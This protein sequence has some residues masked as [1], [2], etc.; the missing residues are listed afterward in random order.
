MLGEP[1]T[2]QLEGKLRELRFHLEKRSV[3]I[4]Y[5]IAPGRP[6]VLLTT[7][8]KSGIPRTARSNG[9][10]EPWATCAAEQHTAEEDDRDG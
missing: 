8:F 10:G 6:I 4:T 3:R 7:F 5:R 2:R 9:P 1:Y